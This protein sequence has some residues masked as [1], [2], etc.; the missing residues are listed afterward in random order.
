MKQKFDITGMGC[1]ACVARIEGDVSKMNGV[2]NVSVNLLKNSMTAEFDEAVATV[3]DIVKTVEN[4][5]Y[6]A[7]PAAAADEKKN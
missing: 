2:K 3:A 7:T 1:A 4:A 5:G 6:G